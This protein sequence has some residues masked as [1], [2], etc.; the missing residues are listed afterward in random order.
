MIKKHI[1]QELKNVTRH[2]SCPLYKASLRITL[3]MMTYLLLST[4]VVTAALQFRATGIFSVKTVV[5][6]KSTAKNTSNPFTKAKFFNTMQPS[7]S[8]E[9]AVKTYVLRVVKR[10]KTSDWTSLSQSNRTKLSL[11]RRCLLRPVSGQVTSSFG[12]RIHPTTRT[13]RFHAGVDFGARRGSSIVAALG[14]KIIFAGWKRGYGLM[15]ILDHGN[16]MKTV[17]AHCSRVFAKKGQVVTKGFRIAKV[18]STGV[19]TGAHLHFEV[20][21]KGNVRNPKRYLVRK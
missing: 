18:G 16:G 9:G 11:S 5:A 6:Q 8:R 15:V 1:S 19:A 4:N 17:Y 21:V 10:L 14:G 13:R 20:R 3:L 7:G 2:A 12:M